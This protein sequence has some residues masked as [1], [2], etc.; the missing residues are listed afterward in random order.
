MFEA[1]ERDQLFDTQIFTKR[2]YEGLSGPRQKGSS[3]GS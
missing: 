1:K 2:V 3:K